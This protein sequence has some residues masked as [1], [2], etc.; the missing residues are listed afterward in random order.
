MLTMGCRGD[1]AAASLT[2]D[3]R[4]CQNRTFFLHL[5]AQNKE[6]EKHYQTSCLFPATR[7][8]G[9]SFWLILTLADEW[10][11]RRTIGEQLEADVLAIRIRN[12]TRRNTDAPSDGKVIGAR[13]RKWRSEGSTR[14]Y[15]PNPHGLLPMQTNH[16][17]IE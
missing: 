7:A 12:G 13:W 2:M 14:R 5:R 1:A 17:S 9:L 6:P 4:Q 15:F 11:D 3:L 10:S 8:A 16:G